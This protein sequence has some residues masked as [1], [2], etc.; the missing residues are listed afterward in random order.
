VGVLWIT[1]GLMWEIPHREAT[2][3]F[4]VM[5]IGS[6]AQI[7]TIFENQVTNKLVAT[8]I[9]IFLKRGKPCGSKGTLDK[10]K[11]KE[12]GELAQIELTLRA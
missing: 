9:K 10:G 8:N 6:R 12:L 2:P 11:I 4:F 3:A 7:L 5:N 1:G